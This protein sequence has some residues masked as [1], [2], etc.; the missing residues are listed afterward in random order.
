VR[1]DARPASSDAGALS[2]AAYSAGT[3]NSSDGRWRARAAKI[4]SGL[5]GP[6]IGTAAA[7]TENGKV[8][9]LPRP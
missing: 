8:M 1:S 3:E 6:S 9:P 5:G 7:P 2:I 4:R